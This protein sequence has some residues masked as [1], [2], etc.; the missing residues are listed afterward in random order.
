[1]EASP[2]RSIIELGD[3]T[4]IQATAFMTGNEEADETRISFSYQSLS[5]GI[6]EINDY[7]TIIAKAPGTAEVRVTG[8]F[9]NKTVSA[10]FNIKIITAARIEID[11][12][13]EIKAG[14]THIYTIKAYYSD[15]SQATPE[16]GDILVHSKDRNT[17]RVDN[18]GMLEA[19]GEGKAVFSVRF[20]QGGTEIV[21]PETLQISSPQQ[22]YSQNPDPLFRF[23]PNPA[24]DRVFIDCP[25]DT[26]LSEIRILS[27]T[28]KIISR[29]PVPET[30]R[31]ELN[32]CHL[33]PG[34]YF[35]TL[36]GK[37]M[38]IVRKLIKL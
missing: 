27:L 21:R 32:V 33:S 17:L 28:G 16:E 1:M 23:Y 35:I 13:A 22:L 9:E 11:I 10:V 34:V 19:I 12:P 7:G 26:E 3:A 37:N 4:G 2:Y 36:T 15:G 18:Q 29:Y 14:E 25:A 31:K 38:E 30:N 6:A 24:S 20:R 8:H 5:P